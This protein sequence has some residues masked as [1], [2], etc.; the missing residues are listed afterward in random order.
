M[1]GGFEKAL[2]EAIDEGLAILGS[3]VANTIYYHVKK[4]S[5]VKREEIPEKLD[6]FHGALEG[7]FGAGAKIIERC[8]AKSLYSKLGLSFT[9]HWSWTIADYVKEAKKIKGE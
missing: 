7:I 6:A 3:G 2:V 9:E 8:I 4:M 1:K 5:Q